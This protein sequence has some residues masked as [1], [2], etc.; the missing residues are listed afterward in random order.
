MIPLLLEALKKR[1]AAGLG[2]LALVRQCKDGDK[3]GPPHIWIGDLP[4]KRSKE[5]WSA[6][7]GVILVPLS[8]HLGDEG[9]EAEV[10]LICVVYNPEDGDGTGAEYDLGHLLSRITRLLLEALETKGCPLDDRFILLPDKSGK[11]L[12]WQKSEQQPKPFMQATMVSTWKY[13]G[14]E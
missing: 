7:P 6:L 11:V 10:A 8:G 2:D 5:D 12:P 14:W 13:K 3:A 4:P 1:L 9:G